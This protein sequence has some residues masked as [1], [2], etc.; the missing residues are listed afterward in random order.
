MP[1]TRTP[2]VPHVGYSQAH[3]ASL[4]LPYGRLQCPINA[5]QRE[6]A[7]PC[8]FV[9]WTALYKIGP[10]LLVNSGSYNNT[11]RPFGRNFLLY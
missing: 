8:L 11:I 10:V 3:F 2:E 5:Y 9:S 4:R 6:S 7:V 1:I